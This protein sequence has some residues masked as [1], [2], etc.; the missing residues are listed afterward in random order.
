MKSASAF[1]RPSWKF[2]MRG[3]TVFFLWRQCRF[4]QLTCSYYVFQWQENIPMRFPVCQLLI[5][6]SGCTSNLPT[7]IA[8]SSFFSLIHNS[9]ENDVFCRN[10]QGTMW[11]TCNSNDVP[12]SHSCS[13]FLTTSL[14]FSNFCLR[15]GFHISQNL[16]FL[17]LSNHI[18]PFFFFFSWVLS[19]LLSVEDHWQHQ[20]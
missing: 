13:Q 14:F 17:H 15:K 11:T 19:F 9:N 20:G 18:L 16:L 5:W 7:F 12:N 8:L 6:C 10:W 4:V 1:L 2:L 3:R